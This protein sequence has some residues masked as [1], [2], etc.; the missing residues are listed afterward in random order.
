MPDA[1]RLVGVGEGA[2][3]ELRRELLLVDDRELVL[4]N[5]QSVVR[6]EGRALGVG[7]VHVLGL[8]DLGRYGALVVEA[9]LDR[10]LA[11]RARVEGDLREH[12]VGLPRLVARAVRLLV[13]GLHD[14]ADA[15]DAVAIGRERLRVAVAAGVALDAHGARGGGREG[16]E[17]DHPADRLRTKQN[18]AAALHDLD[19]AV[20]L[21]GR[22]KIEIRLGVRVDRDGDAVLEHEDTAAAGRV[23]AAHADVEARAA[24]LVLSHE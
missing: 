10:D 5:V 12:V 2:E 24:R 9:D 14:V 17:V 8:A 6:R 3:L 20:A 11:L 16:Q 7:E 21:D 19:L 22:R 13:E 18:A 23:E 15:V 1:T 4:S